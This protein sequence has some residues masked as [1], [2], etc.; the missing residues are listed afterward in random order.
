MLRTAIILVVLGQLLLVSGCMMANPEEQRAKNEP[1]LAEEGITALEPGTKAPALTSETAIGEE[2]TLPTDPGSRVVLFFYPADDTPNTTREMSKL[3]KM[4][5]A[6]EAEGIKLYGVSKGSASEH[7]EYAQQYGITVPLLADEDL[8]ISADYGCA[9]KD[10]LYAQRTFVGIETD[11]TI[12]F[13]ERGFD[14]NYNEK[15]I[16]E[17]FD[18]PAPKE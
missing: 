9:L 10:G 13:F 4:A 1:I 15:T 8:S 5:T 18:P 6:L 7:A 17:W 11:G 14:P 12:A 16:R 2:V 3:N